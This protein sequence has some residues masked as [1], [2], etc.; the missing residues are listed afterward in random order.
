MAGP[1]IVVVAG[2]ITAFLAVK[3]WDGLV[4]D[5]YYKQGLGV[6]QVKVRDQ[7]AAEAGLSVQINYSGRQVQA[8]LQGGGE[9]VVQDKLLLKLI[10]PTRKGEDQTVELTRQGAGFYRGAFETEPVGRFNATLEDEKGDWRLTGVWKTETTDE[11]ILLKPLG[12]AR[13]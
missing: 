6:N 13:N 7:H 4:A 2:L 10:H 1:A 5:D 9:S 8:F 11:P 12:A 3:S